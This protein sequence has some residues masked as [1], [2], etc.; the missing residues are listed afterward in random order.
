MDW[1]S[2]APERTRERK[3]DPLSGSVGCQCRSYRAE[4][5][6]WRWVMK[7]GLG[8]EGRKEERKVEAAWS[9]GV[10]VQRSNGVAWW[11]GWG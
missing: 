1:S 7:V 6:E 3:A 8:E 11:L 10:I 9:S 4:R 5:S 2:V